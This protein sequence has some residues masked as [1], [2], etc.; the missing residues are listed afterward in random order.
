MPG[1]ALKLLLSAREAA[2][3]LGVCQK[4]LWVWTMPRGPIPCLRL[5]HRVLYSVESL[6]AWIEKQAGNGAPEAGRGL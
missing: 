4:T 3:A 5:G 2:A 1:E 6:R